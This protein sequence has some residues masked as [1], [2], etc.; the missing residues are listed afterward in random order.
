MN[1]YIYLL[2]SR[3]TEKLAK[4]R[5]ILSAILIF[6]L[7]KSPNT[8]KLAKLGTILSAI[9]LFCLQKRRDTWKLNICVAKKICFKE[10]N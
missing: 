9:L 4:L 10:F 1:I 7:K 6:V 8:E 3:D 5:T 2:K